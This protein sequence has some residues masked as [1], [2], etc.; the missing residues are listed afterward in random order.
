MRLRVIAASNRQ[1]RWVDE[2]FAEYAKR[3]R[4]GVRL[5]LVQIALGR[6]GSTGDGERARVDEGRRMLASVP[7]GSQVV[8]LR[9]Q[10]AP[11]ST[12]ELVLR[13]EHWLTTGAPV[14][15]LI[16]GPDGLSDDCVARADEHWSLSRLTLPHG[17]ARVTVAEAVYRAW[18]VL[19]GHPYHRS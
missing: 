3:L 12:A 13:L 15:L 16:G 2:G 18:S 17:L 6:R 8:A 11:W 10:G 9:E 19:Q 4:G 14:S 7:D 5:E 1:P